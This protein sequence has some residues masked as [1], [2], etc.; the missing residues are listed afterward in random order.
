MTGD[1]RGDLDDGPWVQED[2]DDYMNRWRWVGGVT[3]N[4]GVGVREGLRSD[5]DFK[6][7]TT[8]AR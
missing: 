4:H 3:P 7:T 6:W 5:T 8:D 2:P 1:P